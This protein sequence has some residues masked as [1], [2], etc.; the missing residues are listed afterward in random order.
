VDFLR[1]RRG[2]C[3]QYAGA[4]AVLVRAAGVPARLALGYTAGDEQR[5]GSRLITTDDAHAWVEVYF[6]SYGWV[7]FDPTPIEEDRAVAL[8]WAPRADADIGTRSGGAAPAPSAPTAAAPT[9]REDRA[10]DGAPSTAAGQGDTGIPWPLLAGAGLV[11]LMAVTFG[12][13][14]AVRVLQRRRRLATGTAGALWDELEATALDLGVRMDPAWTPRRAASELAGTVGRGGKDAAAAADAIPRLARAEEAACYGRAG[15][16]VV[17]PGLGTAL[18][19]ARR[20]LLHSVSRDARLR[21]RLWPASLV[22][23]AGARLT[24]RVRRRLGRRPR[25]RRPHTA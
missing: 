9:L 25:L 12:T 10:A 24:D 11:V 3:E 18:R 21:A 4:M 13:P 16:G 5:D 8:P 7:P 2:F 6:Q 17:D 22:N 15:D 1:L 20:G 19:T 14:A 23:G